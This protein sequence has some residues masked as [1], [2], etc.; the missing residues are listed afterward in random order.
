M[1]GGN[2]PDGKKG[3]NWEGDIERTWDAL[4]EDESGFSENK[5]V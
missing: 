3:Y 1:Y 2:L 4:Q 5:C